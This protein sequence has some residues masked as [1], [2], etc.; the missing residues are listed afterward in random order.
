[1]SMQGLLLYKWKFRWLHRSSRHIAHSTYVLPASKKPP[2]RPNGACDQPPLLRSLK[3]R[4]PT[5]AYLERVVSFFSGIMDPI[6]LLG[7]PQ[8]P[9]YVP[10]FPYA[11]PK[12]TFEHLVGTIQ[13]KVWIVITL[14]FQIV[15]SLRRIWQWK[16]RRG[17]V[18]KT[19]YENIFSWHFSRWIYNSVRT[20]INAVAS[21]QGREYP[22]S[23]ADHFH[24]TLTA[25]VSALSPILQLLMGCLVSIS[26]NACKLDLICMWVM[27]QDQLSSSVNASEDP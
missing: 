22:I 25:W 17:V 4:T 27:S 20:W 23:E 2:H 19:C 21:M 7:H 18:C 8:R 6:M 5:L 15:V 26:R 14:N 9:S 16:T 13:I 1:M 24:T 11:N 10:E 3:Q 12:D